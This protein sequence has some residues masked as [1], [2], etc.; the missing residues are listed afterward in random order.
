M[1]TNTG[2]TTFLT[3]L[4]TLGAFATAATAQDEAGQDVL[5]VSVEEVRIPVAAYDAG[6]RFDPTLTVDD[7][8]VREDG[9]PQRVTGVYRVPAYVLVLADTGGELNPSKTTRLTAEVSA[10][11]VSALRQGD[12]VALMQ[13]SNRA[14]MIQDWSS[15]MTEVLKT[16][17][18]RLL[19]SKRS[20]LAEGLTLATEYLKK[21]PVGNRHLVIISDGLDSGG[22]TSAYGDALKH[23]AASGVTVHVI[24][25]TLLGM[26]AARKPATRP[27]VKNSMPEEGIMSLPKDDANP[28]DQIPDLRS[29]MEVKGGSV[30]DLDR[31]FGRGRKLKKELARREAEF[32]E[33]AVETGG[34]LWLPSTA[35]EM[36]RQAS[37]AAREIDSRYVV[38][39]RPRRPLAD[40]KPGE[41]RRLDVLARRQG[42][43]VR[44]R[45]GYVAKLP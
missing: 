2:L 14:E 31:L 29:R 19:S 15:D 37:E 33:L 23:L 21:S 17:R 32:G 24:S 38:A 43:I 34:G 11:L 9:E 42:L 12:S 27:R 13:V 41:Y 35:E 5:R 26:K 45:R 1:H 44:T 30:V 28:R 18:A 10:G 8:L 36:P 39:Y 3:L 22:A 4:L 40:A 7:L 6:G 20:A 25:Y 16:I